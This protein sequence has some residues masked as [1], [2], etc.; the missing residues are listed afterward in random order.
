VGLVAV[1][2]KVWLVLGL[3]FLLGLLRRAWRS[4]RA[5]RRAASAPRTAG[6]PPPDRAAVLARRAGRLFADA[7]AAR[8]RSG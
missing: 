7:K 5:R 8:R 3:L 4:W 2:P 1:N 6:A